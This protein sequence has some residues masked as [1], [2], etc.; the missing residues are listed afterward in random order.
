MKAEIRAIENATRLSELDLHR[1]DRVLEGYLGR[2]GEVLRGDALRAR[3]ALRKL[4]VDR[5]SF[6]P[7][8][9]AGH[10]TYRLEANVTFGRILA[11]E[12]CSS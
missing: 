2:I 11:E 3:Q 4:L 5:I 10:R 8:E 12:P 7:V 9:A 6:V 1:V